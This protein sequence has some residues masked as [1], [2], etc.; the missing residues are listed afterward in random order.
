M[1]EGNTELLFVGERYY[2][3]T[4]CL[5]GD[6]ITEVSAFD[7]GY[8]EVCFVIELLQELHNYLIGVRTSFIDIVT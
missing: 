4:F 7:S 8:I 5:A 6:C 2:D 3:E 1:I